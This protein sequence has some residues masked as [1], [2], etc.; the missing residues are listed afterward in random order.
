MA[1]GA[2]WESGNTLALIDAI[3]GH[4]RRVD[5]GFEGEAHARFNSGLIGAARAIGMSEEDI[6]EA[7]ESDRCL[8][9]YEP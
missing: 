9:V 1:N 6:R 4:T 7:F 2:W 8:T 3:A 5:G